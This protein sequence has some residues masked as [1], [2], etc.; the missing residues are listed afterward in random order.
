MVGVL[1]TVLVEIQPWTASREE[2]G[3]LVGECC[4]DNGAIE[5]N[6]VIFE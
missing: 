5:W 3:T 6:A 1:P 4:R 2:A